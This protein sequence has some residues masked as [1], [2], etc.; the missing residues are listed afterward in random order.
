MFN[1]KLIGGDKKAKAKAKAKS[2]KKTVDKLEGKRNKLPLIVWY[3][4]ALCRLSYTNYIFFGQGL[5]F[6][7]N[8]KVSEKLGRR[9]FLNI[10]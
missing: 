7:F 3:C 2:K 10:Y 9:I 5:K 4:T 8:L 6:I 1:N